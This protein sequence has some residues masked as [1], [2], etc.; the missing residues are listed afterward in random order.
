MSQ[1]TRETVER[2]AYA[3]V[4]APVAAIKALGARVS[5]MREALESSRKE[6]NHDLAAEINEWIAQGEQVIDRAME[7]I[8]A[9]GM[10]DDLR[11]AV[12]KTRRSAEV[13]VRKATRTIDEGLDV[14][15]PDT[16][17]S[18]INGIGPN[19]AEQLTEAGVP[20]VTDFLS[21][22]GTEEDIAK[23]A[24]VSGF[25]AGTIESWRHQVDLSRVKGIGGAYQRSLHRVDVWTL[26]E[27]S[28]AGPEE[29]TERLG[30]IQS[31]DAAE[32]TPSI[33]QVRQWVNKAQS[34]VSSS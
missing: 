10:V 32:Q 18:R 34:L 2:A 11:T 20:G 27:L 28:Q 31:P 23:L 16:H 8:R 17:L 21:A 14:V 3:A 26:R 13:G 30:S 1:Q 7:R 19:Y 22:T 5:E 29:L 33:Y 12:E 24:E 6:M 15:V 25:S 4:G 9:A